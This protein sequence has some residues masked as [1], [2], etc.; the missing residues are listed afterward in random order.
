MS[1]D[2]HQ[3]GRF[4]NSR[5]PFV[6]AVSAHPNAT[7]APPPLLQ[8]LVIYVSWRPALRRWGVYMYTQIN[9]DKQCA[10]EATCTQ[11]AV[12][13]LT[14]NVHISATL[15]DPL[16]SPGQSHLVYAYTAVH[17][18]ASLMTTPSV[19]DWRW[20]ETTRN[21]VWP[22]EHSIQWSCGP[23]KYLALAYRLL[24]VRLTCISCFLPISQSTL[25]WFL[26][27]FEKTYCRSPAKYCTIFISLYKPIKLV[28]LKF[29]NCIRPTCQMV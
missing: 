10:L 3:D 6:L 12:D 18:H 9:S 20:S 8:S 27:D 25:N 19:H 17:I 23:P 26:W 15:G 7:S 21:Y 29:K 5:S 28:R 16:A 13:T 14:C 1:S 22:P 2:R 24:A 4:A 11:W